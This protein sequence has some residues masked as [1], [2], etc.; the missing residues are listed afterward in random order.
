M[1]K[2]VEAWTKRNAVLYLIEDTKEKLLDES[3]TDKELTELND[4][5]D[6]LYSIRKTEHDLKKGNVTYQVDVGK[7]VASGIGLLGI[8]MILGYEKEDI[9]TSKSLS[10]AQRLL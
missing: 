4:K 3:L 6:M 9:V 7:L 10:I 8:A 5:L 1:N 2:L